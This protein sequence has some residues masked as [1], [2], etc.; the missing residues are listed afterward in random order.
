VNTYL[1]QRREH[2]LD[3]AYDHD[4]KTN[5]NVEALKN[6]EDKEREDDINVYME[7]SKRCT[8]VCC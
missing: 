8:S 2:L 3:R 4:L 1:D 5:T 7:R 6:I